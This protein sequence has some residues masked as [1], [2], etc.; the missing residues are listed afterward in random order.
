MIV[1]VAWQFRLSS[2]ETAV[3]QKLKI[4]RWQGH[5]EVAIPMGF[6]LVPSSKNSVVGGAS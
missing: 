4:R 6:S 5:V 3:N 2:Y 1:M